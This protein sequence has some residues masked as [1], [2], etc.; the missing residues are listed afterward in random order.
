MK[1][2]DMRKDRII[3]VREILPGI[4]FA[5]E[6]ELF[7]ATDAFDDSETTRLCV[8]IGDGKTTKFLLDRMVLLA[9]VKAVVR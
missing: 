2:E 7:L 9:D 6:D 4:V 8:R 5:W 3:A 1:I